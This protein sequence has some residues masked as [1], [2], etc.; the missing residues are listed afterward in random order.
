MGVAQTPHRHALAIA[1][2][3]V[4]EQRPAVRGSKRRRISVS[5][6]TASRADHDSSA[7]PPFD[8]VIR[9][10]HS[11]HAHSA[12][13]V[14]EVSTEKAR[15]MTYR[16]FVLRGVVLRGTT[17]GGSSPGVVEWALRI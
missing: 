6:S 5:V 14:A 13:A 15:M 17:C 7:V 3:F 1:N 11:T 4:V 2:S 12:C 9:C 8:G 10:S 16:F